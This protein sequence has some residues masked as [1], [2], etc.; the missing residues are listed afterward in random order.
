MGRQS[1]KMPSS[2]CESDNDE[3][4]KRDGIGAHPER[5]ADD[6]VSDKQITVDLD[7]DGT[8]LKLFGNQKEVIR[9]VSPFQST[10][11]LARSPPAQTRAPSVVEWL[12]KRVI[13]PKTRKWSSAEELSL[14]DD[15]ASAPTREG[16]VS[17]IRNL[18][19]ELEKL[20]LGHPTTK[21]EIKITSMKLINAINSTFD[22]E[23]KDEI[24]LSKTRQDIENNSLPDK[25]VMCNVSTQ[26][27]EPEQ[28]QPT[29]SQE[30]ETKRKVKNIRDQFDKVVD[31]SVLE[32]DWPRQTF[33]KAFM[34]SQSLKK[35]GS[36]MPIAAVVNVNNLKQDMVMKA[37]SHFIPAI[38]TIEKEDLPMAKWLQIT[39]EET[40]A[41]S[42]KDSQNTK[43]QIALVWPDMI[44]E[45]TEIDMIRIMEWTKHIKSE[46]KARKL[47][48]I[49]VIAPSQTNIT[50]LRK[51]L[52]WEL[53]SENVKVLIKANKVQSKEYK[54]ENKVRR[55]RPETIVVRA[56]NENTTYAD[57]IKQLKA[58]ISPDESGVAIKKLSKSSNGN[59]K[60]LLTEN[61][62]GGKER[63][64]EE[65]K[66]KISCAQNAALQTK[67][68]GVIIFDLE[69]DV[70][71]DEVK[72]TI[73]EEL[74]TSAGDIGVNEIRKTRAG[75]NMVTVYLP[76]EKARQLI[77]MKRIKI[78]W[79]PCRIKEKF[80]PQL[81]F[82]CQSF[83]HLSS[84]CKNE[85][86]AG[87]RCLKCGEIGHVAKDCKKEDSCFMCNCTGHRAN[88]MVCAKYRELVH[89][90]KSGKN[91]NYAVQQ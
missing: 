71:Q 90:M 56:D 20:V 84:T 48:K 23:T 28:T 24:L 62:S 65:I 46:I 11:S 44:V 49:A 87:R 68:Q 76:S 55:P 37:L 45:D 5:P 59:V 16:E 80:D 63:F 79:T 47:E 91:P 57:I 10:T 43:S 73:S 41:I 38:K 52:E 30:L 35:L 29:S 61:K 7:K 82:R 12:N 89:N 4:E 21:R 53:H 72:K 15:F 32:L 9:S 14:N 86:V 88:S 26:T 51:I 50:K 42:G 39:H 2:E 34:S 77:A 54:A 64:L 60:L 83:G 3:K 70:S 75:A 19:T 58:N 67:Q 40:T 18:A 13:S 33:L 27:D 69:E 22:K 6:G 66:N 78:G 25:P 8:P 85:R 81:C 31:G 74:N 1:P 17:K 36:E